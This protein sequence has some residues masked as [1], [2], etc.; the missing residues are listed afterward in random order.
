LIAPCADDLLVA[1]PVS[2]AVNRAAND[3]AGLIEPYA[4][5]PDVEAPVAPRKRRVAASDEPTLL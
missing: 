2:P 5:P 3:S 1:H 4:V